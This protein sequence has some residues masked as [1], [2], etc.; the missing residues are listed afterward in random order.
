M[1]GSWQLTPASV[2]A[3]VAAQR[4]I[5][6]FLAQLREQLTQPLPPLLEVA[7]RAWAGNRPTSALGI[8]QLFRCTQPAI[9]QAIAESALFRPYIRA[10]LGPTTLLIDEWQVAAFRDRLAWA[11]LEVVGLWDGEEQR[12]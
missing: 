5:A 10:V 1:D 11:G 12:A 8:G 3:A 7:L 2:Q 4:P 9:V 6:S